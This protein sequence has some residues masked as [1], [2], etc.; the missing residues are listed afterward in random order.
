M[1]SGK[2]KK[3]GSPSKSRKKS[4]DPKYGPMLTDQ[5][6]ADRLGWAKVTLQMRRAE[7]LPVPNYV[8]FSLRRCATPEVEVTKFIEKHLVEVV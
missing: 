8:K 4:A 1:P 2:S 7:G 6:V 3:P 5:E